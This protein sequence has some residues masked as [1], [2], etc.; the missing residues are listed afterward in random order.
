MELQQRTY[1][2][3]IL[4][5]AQ[6]T[7]EFRKVG[8][9]ALLRFLRQSKVFGIKRLESRFHLT[10]RWHLVR[11][12]PQCLQFFDDR[13]DELPVLIQIKTW[14]SRLEVYSTYFAAG[15]NALILALRRFLN[16]TALLYSLSLLAFN[17]SRA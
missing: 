9:K 3:R 12:R 17:A 7:A 13:V 6:Y 5:R 16:S 8:L 14:M 15:F 11:F 10:S 2:G 4:D 1:L